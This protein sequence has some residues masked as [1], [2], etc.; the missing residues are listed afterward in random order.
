MIFVLALYSLS[1]PLSL[2]GL[3]EYRGELMVDILKPKGVSLGLTFT[4]GGSFTVSKLK[5]AGIAD[6]CGA[7]RVGGPA[8]VCQQGTLGGQVY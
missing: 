7:L 3:N 1:L 2:E 6:R 5:A 8:S 4:P